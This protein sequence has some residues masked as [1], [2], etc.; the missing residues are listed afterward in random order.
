MTS[1]PDEHLRWLRWARELQA[2]SQTGLHFTKDPFDKER[3]ERVRAIAAEML[4]AQSHHSYEKILGAFA[5]Q[6]GYATPK[7]D[8]RGAV[9]RDG[10]ILLVRE[11]VDGGR[12][13]LPGG[14]ADINLSPS[15]NAVREV[16][17]ETGYRVEVVKLAGVHDRVMQ[18]RHGPDQP[19]HV[20][21]LFF[22]CRIIGGSPSESTETEQP[23]FFGRDEIPELSEGRTTRA[24]IARMFAHADDP[25]LPC[26]FD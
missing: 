23:T 3:Y 15:A 26:E 1:E 25:S 17:E 14:W 8:T 6:W 19:F 24:H 16:W 13:T 18:S 10:K 2:L 4:A 22:L 5:D 9:F 7:V 21:K 12:W 20:Y 11:I